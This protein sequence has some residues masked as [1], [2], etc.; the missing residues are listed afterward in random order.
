M[1]K[2]KTTTFI[3][4]IFMIHRFY[5]GKTGTA[6]LYL[7]TL[8]GFGIWYFIDMYRLVNDTLTDSDGKRLVSTGNPLVE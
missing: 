4:M 7:L 5:L 3:L 2:R 1:A 6:I 8:G